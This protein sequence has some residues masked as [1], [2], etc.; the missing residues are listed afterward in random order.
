MQQLEDVDPELLD[1]AIRQLLARRE[2]HPNPAREAAI[3]E[4]IGRSRE[5]M[6]WAEMLIGQGPATPYELAKVLTGVAIGLEVGYE[7]GARG[8]NLRRTWARETPISGGKAVD[9]ED[10][11]K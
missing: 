8:E 11:S 6:E 3:V 1:Q 2:Q 4:R 5:M 7:L 10:K 9:P